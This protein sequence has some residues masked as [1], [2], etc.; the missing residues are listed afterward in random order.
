MSAHRSYHCADFPVVVRR[1]VAIKQLHSAC[2]A[3]VRV[4]QGAVHVV[5]AFASLDSRAAGR[6]CFCVPSAPSLALQLVL[7]L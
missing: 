5:A 7:L 3:E 1:R 4:A 2:V 6:A